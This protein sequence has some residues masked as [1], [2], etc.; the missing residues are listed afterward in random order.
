MSSLICLKVSIGQQF[1]RLSVSSE[2]TWNQDLFPRLMEIFSKD[3][4][5][6]MK[7]EYLDDEGD[8]IILNTNS[9]WIEAQRIKQQQQKVIRLRLNKEEQEGDIGSSSSSSSSSKSDG[10][11]Q[12]RRF[13]KV[14]MME[15]MI[16]KKAEALQK[17]IEQF[18][19]KGL[20]DLPQSIKDLILEATAAQKKHPTTP[21]KEGCRSKWVA[22]RIYNELALQ[23]HDY[24]LSKVE[25]DTESAAKLLQAA[26]LIGRK[27]FP[28]FGYEATCV[29]C[30]VGKSEE[31][32]TMLKQAI[33]E[34]GWN[35]VKMMEND[36]GLNLIRSDKSFEELHQLVIKNSN[37]GSKRMHHHGH[38]HDHD[39]GNGHQHHYGRHGHNK[40]HGGGG[41][42]ELRE[43]IGCGFPR[44]G[45]RW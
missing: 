31:A 26:A 21:S 5:S 24:G 34:F 37:E 27:R 10:D 25:K 14:K 45:R 12:R 35:D 11:E 39:H 20:E 38:D 7:V 13:G 6:K 30:K 29:L 16:G 40:K 17:V 41:C 18:E 43:M 1:H 9:E 3:I 15:E 28:D 33:E 36:E 8:W 23:L 22:F 44:F 2:A 19:S 42:G 32:M 4:G